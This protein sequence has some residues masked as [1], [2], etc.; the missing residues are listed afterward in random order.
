MSAMV[1]VSGLLSAMRS[2]TASVT[3][4][5]CRSFLLLQLSPYSLRRLRPH[6]L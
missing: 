5:Q 4:L 3:V 2:V 1:T 6:R